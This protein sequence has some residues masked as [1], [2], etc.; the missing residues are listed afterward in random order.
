MNEGLLTVKFLY[1][2]I[3]PAMLEPIAALELRCFADPWSLSQIG[4]ELESDLCV[5][6]VMVD[7]C[8][9]FLVGYALGRVVADEMEILRLAVHPTVR[10]KGAGRSL[11]TSLLTDGAVRGARA[12]YLEVSGANKPAIALYYS[13][14]FGMQGIRKGYYDEGKSDALVM[15][16]PLSGSGEG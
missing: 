8:S 15:A 5:G 2:K 14:G 9:S 6:R 7:P 10:R 11:L 4:Q 13:I 16:L 3:E 1:R 12:A